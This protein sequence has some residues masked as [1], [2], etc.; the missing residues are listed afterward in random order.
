MRS[1][2]FLGPEKLSEDKC[3]EI[4]FVQDSN[5]IIWVGRFRSLAL[6]PQELPTTCLNEQQASIFFK[7]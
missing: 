1:T 5:G 2:S 3:F 7:T 4:S 6:K